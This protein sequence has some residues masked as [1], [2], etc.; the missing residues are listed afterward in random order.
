VFDLARFW[1]CLFCS[2]EYASSQGNETKEER[3]LRLDIEAKKREFFQK[4]RQRKQMIEM[5]PLLMK[6]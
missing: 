3:D 6:N 2:E 5:I 1:S 4:F